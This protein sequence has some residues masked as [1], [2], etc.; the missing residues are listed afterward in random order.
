MEKFI[1]LEGPDRVGKDTQLKLLLPKLINL[2]THIIHYSFFSGLKNEDLLKYNKTLYKDLFLLCEQSK[3]RN[4]IFNRSHLGE[5]VYGF[6]Y[7]NYNVDYVFEIEKEFKNKNFWKNI[8]L[9]VL[10]DDKNNLIQRE[11]G[12]SFSKDLNKKQNELDRFCQ[13]YDKSFIKN[14]I[15][16][17]CDN[18][19]I[20]EIK[21]NINEFVF[22]KTI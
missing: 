13:L 11:D 12:K 1:I 5:Y 18:K 19:S 16:I 3:N 20:N 22:N 21:E 7:R 2:P 8:Y 4:L 6:L 17:N 9:I 15:L 14:K 10:I